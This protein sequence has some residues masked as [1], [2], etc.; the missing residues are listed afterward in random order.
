MRDFEAPETSFVPACPLSSPLERTIEQMPSDQETKEKASRLIP[1]DGLKKSIGDDRPP[2]T[3]WDTL[4]VK[5]RLVEMMQVLNRLPARI[6]PRAYSNSMPRHLYDSDDL[7]GQREFFDLRQYARVAAIE[8]MTRNRNRVR[9]M[10]SAAEI[11]RAEEAM[12]W[13]MR[14]LKLKEK[15]VLAEAVC[16]GALWTMAGDDVVAACKRVAISRR[17]FYRRQDLG[18][19]IIAIG[20]T[21]DRVLP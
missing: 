18:L 9:V 13:P 19:Y 7:R 8:V 3:K 5:E 10:P 2:R 14:Y 4:L 16:L 17:T 6:G 15:S 12:E 20:L 21:R 11:T 1:G